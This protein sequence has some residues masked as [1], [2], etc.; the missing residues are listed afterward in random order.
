MLIVA[1][2]PNTLNGVMLNVVMLSVDMLSVDMLSIMGHLRNVKYLSQK[3]SKVA[4]ANLYFHL[5][6]LVL[7]CFGCI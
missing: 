2:K 6:W 7:T 1:N 3:V 5:P 4:I